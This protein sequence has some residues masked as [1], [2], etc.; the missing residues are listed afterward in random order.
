MYQ[1][2]PKLSRQSLLNL[3]WL[4]SKLVAFQYRIATVRSFG[5]SVAMHIF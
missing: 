1:V 3:A 4:S 5:P 2:A